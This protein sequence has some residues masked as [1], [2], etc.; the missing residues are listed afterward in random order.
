MDPSDRTRSPRDD[1]VGSSLSNLGNSLLA[2]LRTRSADHWLFFAVGVIVG[3][4]IS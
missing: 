2:Y 1:D 4:L 3:L